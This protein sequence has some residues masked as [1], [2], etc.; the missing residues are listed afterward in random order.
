MNLAKNWQNILKN[1]FDQTYYHDLS[2]YL[3]QQAQLKQIVYPSDDDIFNAFNLTSFKKVK[4]IIIGQDPYHGAGQAHGLSFSVPTGVKI[5]PSLKNIYKELSSDLNMDLPATGDLSKWAKQGVLLLNSTLTVAAKQP[6]SHQKK[7]WEVF[8]DRV[9][10][11][12]SQKK[13]N[14]IFILWGSPAQKKA[15]L[16]DAKK[17]LILKSVHPSPL[18]SYRGFFGSKPFSKT[19]QYLKQKNISPID[20]RL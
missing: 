6:A 11:L 20:W 3:A 7:G 14:L 2:N 9:I 5:P 12:L 17:H 10:Q 13:E 16:I 4:V 1:E 18:S 19:N 8:T 15:K